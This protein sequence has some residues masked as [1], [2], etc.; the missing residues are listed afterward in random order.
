M[1]AYRE[2]SIEIHPRRPR[3]RAGRIAFGFMSVFVLALILRNSEIAIHHM[4]QGLRLCATSVIPS[5]FPFMV[6]SELIVSGGAV[7]S[8]G[9]LL[10]RPMRFL[11]G[12]GRESGCAVMLGLVC[13]FPIGTRCAL[14]LYRQGKIDHAELTRLLTFCNMPSSAFLIS[15]VGVSLFGD[16]RFGIL[17][18]AATLL[19]AVLIGILGNL[20]TRK[21]TTPAPTP[22]PQ[23]DV[24]VP[25]SGV[26][27]FPEAIRSSAFAMLQICAFVV[28]FSA[29]VGTMEHLP[30][31]QS[32]S[33]PLCALFFGFFEM[34]GGVARAAAWQAEGAK[35]MCAFL[36]GWS[37][38]SVHFQMMSLC[39]DERI[40]FRPYFFAK[41]AHG[42]LNVLLTFL[43]TVCIGANQ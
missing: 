40:S 11:F 36:V 37:G 20:F 23:A 28:F 31:C 42:V 29:F 1:T 32:L 8:L 26:A 41:A 33:E 39:A 22:V 43:L 15:A 25:P 2:K 16:R 18:Y 13:G 34:T 35:L 27:A 5:L 21:K 4:S 10:A 38:L 30:L 9:K 24:L 12:I 3:I 7:Q 17:L 19:S 14:T 6:A